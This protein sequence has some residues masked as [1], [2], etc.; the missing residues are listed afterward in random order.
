M[1]LERDIQR[2]ILDYL[3]LKRVFHYR[4]NSGALKTEAGGFVRFGTAGSPDIVCVIAGQYVGI[5]VKN[6]KG[7]L[8]PLQESFAAGLQAAGGKYLVARCLE[9]VI[10]AGI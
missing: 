5:E 6:N 9:D 1:A 7:R 2:Q 4:Q 3:A 10:N 8:S